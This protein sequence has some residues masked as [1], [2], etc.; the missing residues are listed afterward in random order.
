LR[1]VVIVDHLVVQLAGGLAPVQV[2]LEAMSSF[3]DPE[4]SRTSRRSAGC[5]VRLLLVMPQLP[6]SWSVGVAL[7]PV[8]VLVLVFPFVFRLMLVSVPRRPLVLMIALLP[9]IGVGPPQAKN[10]TAVEA[11]APQSNTQVVRLIIRSP[12]ML[13][14]LNLRAVNRVSRLWGNPTVH[15]FIEY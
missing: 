4:R 9:G 1:A 7:S 8:L 10:A 5:W 11:A 15:L 2:E 13:T 3:I 14:S 12:V 6:P